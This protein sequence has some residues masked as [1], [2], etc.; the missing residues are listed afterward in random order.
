MVGSDNTDVHNGI[1]FASFGQGFPI[2]GA[3]IGNGEPQQSDLEPARRGASITLTSS[4][5]GA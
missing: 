4:W 2:P 1:P 5:G 3:R